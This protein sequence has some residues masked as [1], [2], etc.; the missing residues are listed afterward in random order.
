MT[1]KVTPG[2]PAYSPT[3]YQIR[4][5]IAKLLV[6]LRCQVKIREGQA[7]AIEWGYGCNVGSVVMA[8]VSWRRSK[9]GIGCHVA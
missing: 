9:I 8:D 1:H 4:S 6:S 5:A 2:K 7:E 3:Q